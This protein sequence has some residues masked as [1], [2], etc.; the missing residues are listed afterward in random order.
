M[1]ARDLLGRIPHPTK[2]EIQEGMGG[3]L[4]RCGCY[5]Q[6]TEAVLGAAAAAD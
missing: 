5:Y 4:C 1:A 2:A 3:N 6:I